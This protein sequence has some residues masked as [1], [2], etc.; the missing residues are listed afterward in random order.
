VGSVGVHL[1]KYEKSSIEFYG[2]KFELPRERQQAIAFFHKTM[3][4]EQHDRTKDLVA[5]VAGRCEVELPSREARDRELMSW[6]EVREVGNNGV[7]ISSHTHTHR[8]LATLDPP[9]QKE[10]LASSKACLE[11]KIGH[12]V[13]SIAYPVGG[14]RHFTAETRR[15]AEECGYSL[16]YSFCTGTNRFGDISAYDVRRIGPPISIPLLAGTTVLPEVFDWDQASATAARSPTRRAEKALR[17][18]RVHVRGEFPDRHPH[19]RRQRARHGL[20]LEGS[21][22]RL[23]DVH[24]DLRDR[25]RSFH[26]RRQREHS[27]IRRD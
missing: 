16:G 14:Y 25:P 7:T 10:E 21:V 17:L 13:K 19:L 11:E 18:R 6:E 22:R 1:Q 15:I 24:A 4:L 3:Q 23:L 12:R 27:K 2:K 9:A 20:A 5:E 26:L 8:V